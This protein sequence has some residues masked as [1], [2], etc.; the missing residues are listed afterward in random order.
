MTEVKLLPKAKAVIPLSS[1]RE[2]LNLH[3]DVEITHIDTL[4]DPYA[5]VLYLRSEN[6][7]PVPEDAEA[8]GISQ[9]ERQRFLAATE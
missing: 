5:V 2:A 3:D 9:Y 6:F 4:S 1:L 8:P 7:P